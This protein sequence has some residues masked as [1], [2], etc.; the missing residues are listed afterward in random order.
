MPCYVFRLIFISF[1]YLAILFFKIFIN[2]WYKSLKG[3]WR[4]VFK[5]R[6]FTTLSK[7]YFLS[8]D[9]CDFFIRILIFYKS[10]GS[11]VKKK[12]IHLGIYRLKETTALI[13]INLENKMKVNAL[14]FIE[15]HKKKIDVPEEMTLNKFIRYIFSESIQ[16]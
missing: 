9:T 10:G 8:T 3:L 16:F 2:Q 15:K 7:D 6:S 11:F 12:K 1:L 13:P 14:V 5:D 4:D